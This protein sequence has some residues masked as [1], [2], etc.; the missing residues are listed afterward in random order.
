MKV[1]STSS[2]IYRNLSNS[3][4]RPG[5]WEFSANVLAREVRVAKTLG[6]SRSSRRDRLRRPEL[7]HAGTIIKTS[8]ENSKNS[9]LETRRNWEC[10][11][12]QRGYGKWRVLWQECRELSFTEGYPVCIS[13]SLVWKPFHGDTPFSSCLDRAPR[14]AVSV[15][16]L[17]PGIHSVPGIS[18]L[19]SAEM[20]VAAAAAVEAPAPLCTRRGEGNISMMITPPGAFYPIY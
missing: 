13:P 19:F 8:G 3:Y 14:K 4:S 15:R 1:R 7:R 12:F 11:R 18:S 10:R 6:Y 16:C 9:C 5:L 17:V 2:L 20:T